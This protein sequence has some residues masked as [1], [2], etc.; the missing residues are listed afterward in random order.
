MSGIRGIGVEKTTF[1][2]ESTTA[3]WM[4]EKLLH[5]IQVIP[6]FDKI[7]L[8]MDFIDRNELFIDAKKKVIT[9]KSCE[10]PYL[11]FSRN[12]NLLWQLLD[13]SAVFVYPLVWCLLKMEKK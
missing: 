11:K 9:R 5:K 12:C 13:L 8:G 1:L 3:V 4:G 6:N 7:L 2:G 10:A